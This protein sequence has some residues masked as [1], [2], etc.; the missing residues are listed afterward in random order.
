MSFVTLCHPPGQLNELLSA[1]KLVKLNGWEAGFGQNIAKTRAMEMAAMWMCHI[2]DH[3]FGAVQQIVPVA[4]LL[5]IFGVYT[6]TGNQLT[7]SVTF[8]AL[9]LLEEVRQPILSV[10]NVVSN[11]I[12][13]WSA[14]ARVAS[15]LDAEQLDADAVHR[16]EAA[17]AGEAAISV[18]VRAPRNYYVEPATRIPKPKSWQRCSRATVSAVF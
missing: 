8:T 12:R 17:G 3:L 9:A 7:P 4:T 16:L 13:A 11:L 2:F 15:F 14:I 1:I 18:T 6:Y 10:G 5:T